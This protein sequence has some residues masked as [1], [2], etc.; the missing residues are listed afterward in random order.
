MKTRL[1]AIIVEMIFVVPDDDLYEER[2]NVM[3]AINSSLEWDEW[4]N[5][6]F[7][8]EIKDRK[9]TKEEIKFFNRE[10]GTTAHRFTHDESGNPVTPRGDDDE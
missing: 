5:V 3:S 6:V 8:Y 4:P 1:R 9:A 10:T 2:D 7:S